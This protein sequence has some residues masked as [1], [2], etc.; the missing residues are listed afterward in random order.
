MTVMLPWFTLLCGT[1]CL[2]VLGYRLSRRRVDIGKLGCASLMLLIC[3]KALLHWKPH[4]EFA[5]FPWPDYAYLQQFSIYPLV[6]LFFGL[7]AAQMP[8][9]WNRAVVAA[10]GMG[11][12]SYGAYEN[13]WMAWPEEYG[14]Q[15]Y[16]DQHNHRPQTTHFTCG[17]A[18]C[19]TACAYLG[20]RRSERHLA[21][22]CLTHE[23]GS[24]LFNLYRGLRLTLPEE[25]FS[26]Q[27]LDLPAAEL[28]AE[29][30]VVV[31]S[32]RGGGHALCLVGEGDQVRVHDPLDPEP[33]VWTPAEL[34]KNYRGPVVLVASLAPARPPR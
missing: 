28:L 6:A 29:G 16:A 5:L 22:L 23:N 4:W 1:A 9:A 15:V 13:S 3:G 14:Q 20:V 11:F 31:T 12:L 25:Q 24:R 27:I 8:V 10:C 19:V 30:T 34:H 21:R 26:V 33:K 32:N 18:A 2:G 7:A 17:P